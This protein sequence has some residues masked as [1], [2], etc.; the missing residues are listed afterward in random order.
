VCKAHPAVSWRGA[1]SRAVEFQGLREAILRTFCM[2]L[3]ESEPSRRFAVPLAEQDTESD[4]AHSTLARLLN[5]AVDD[6]H[7]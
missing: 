5:G 1:F 6:K 3:Q 7:P 2:T 4:P